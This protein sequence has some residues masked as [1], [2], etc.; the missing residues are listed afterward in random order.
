[1][2]TS[3]PWDVPPM[4]N[5]DTVYILG[6]SPS[7]ASENLSLI[8]NKRCIGV[9]DSF[10]LGSWVDVCWFGDERWLDWNRKCLRKFGGVKACCVPSLL[11]KPPI[12]GIKVLDRG[13]PQGIETRR[14][15]VSWNNNSGGSAIN[16]AYHLG[17][18][19]IVLLGFSMKV[20]NG[21]DNWHDLHHVHSKENDSQYPVFL[22]AF[23]VIC[24]EA[25]KL[26]IVLINSTMDSAIPEKLMPKIPLEVV[27]R[28]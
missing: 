10:R 18:K 2:H 5:G 17:A 27:V 24:R 15:I 28:G 8:H 25:Y 11:T 26:G 12:Q 3:K 14:G 1:M 20:I 6:G 9:N 23:S 19:R 4:W 22:E 21:K 7:L 13:R 16:L